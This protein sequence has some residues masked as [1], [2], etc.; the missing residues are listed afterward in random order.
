M[1]TIS[2]PITEAEILAQVVSP[3]DA[4][5]PPEVAKA[6]L[7]LGFRNSALTKMRELVDKNNRGDLNAAENSDMEKYLRVGQFL[8]LLQAKARLSLR[9][10]GTTP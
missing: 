1:E 8:D 7:R 2:P 3:E 6:I 10:S 4:D 9:Q 5:L